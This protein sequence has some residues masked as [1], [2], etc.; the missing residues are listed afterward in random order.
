MGIHVCACTLVCAHIPRFSPALHIPLFFILL[1]LMLRCSV[2][3]V[4]ETAFKDIAGWAL[5]NV[6]TSTPTRL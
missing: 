6:G 1:F 2:H 3:P 5:I 4:K